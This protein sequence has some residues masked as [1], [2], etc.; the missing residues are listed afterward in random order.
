MWDAVKRFVPSLSNKKNA[1]DIAVSDIDELDDTLG[2]YVF[3]YVLDRKSY[4]R[5]VREAMR[6]LA[7]AVIK[8]G[9]VLTDT[10]TVYHVR[11]KDGKMEIRWVDGGAGRYWNFYVYTDGN[12]TWDACVID[13][14][15][16][17][18]GIRFEMCYEASFIRTEYLARLVRSHP[19]GPDIRI[20]SGN[21]DVGQQSGL[22]LPMVRDVLAHAARAY[23]K[24]EHV[25]DWAWKLFA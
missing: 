13:A 12:H 11:T 22:T 16:C 19:G 25:P 8:N 20:Y 2:G 24:P 10:D 6:K 21:E 7:D 1:A 23:N 4:M 18:K 14:G 17:D 9:E 5:L 15:T 3:S